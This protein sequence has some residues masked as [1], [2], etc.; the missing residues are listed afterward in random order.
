VYEYISMIERAGHKAIVL[1]MDECC[2]SSGA[3]Y[4]YS[5]KDLTEILNSSV[6][7]LREHGWPAN[8]AGFVRKV[9]AEW[10]DKDHP[11]LPV[12]RRAFGD[13]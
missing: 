7:L 2:I 11:M 4:A 8:P 5:A 9:A 12:I 6:P 10:L 13:G 3:V 1:G